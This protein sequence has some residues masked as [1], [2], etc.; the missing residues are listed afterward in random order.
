MGQ[1]GTIL[2]D[3]Y[4][5]VRMV[6]EG[7]MGV[8]YEG[9]HLALGRK[10]AIKMLHPEFASVDQATQ[11]FMQEAQIAGSLGHPNLCE[12]TDIGTTSEGVP[13]MVMPFL[14]GETLADAVSDAQE[15]GEGFEAAR[16]VGIVGQILSALRPAHEA[17]IVH[18]DLK[19]ENVFLMKA[20]DRDDFVKILDFGISKIVGGAK[21]S[22]RR[23]TS[24]GVVVGTPYYMAPEQASGSR[25]LDHRVD[26]YAVG[27]LLYELLTGQP[28]YE[29][30]TYNE[31]IIKIVK[32]D[33]VSPDVLNPRIPEP[34]VAVIMRALAKDREDRFQDVQTFQKALLVAGQ[35]V[36][37]AVGRVGPPTEGEPSAKAQEVGTLA[38]AAAEI[39]GTVATVS[40]H[41]KIADRRS[42][43][44]AWAVGGGLA[45]LVAL[46]IFFSGVLR[47]GEEGGAPKPVG[48]DGIQDPPMRRAVPDGAPAAGPSR[49]PLVTIEF[50]G[51]GARGRVTLGGKVL[52]GGKVTV[53]RS[54][55]KLGYRAEAPGH[56]PVEGSVTPDRDQVVEIRLTAEPGLGDPSRPG[57]PRPPEVSG[58]AMGPWTAMPPGGP[59]MDIS[60]VMQPPTGTGAIMGR[61]GTSLK[62]DYDAED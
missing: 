37:E 6:G 57:A 5:V 19:P 51:L 28:P 20:G 1:E 39:R 24:T 42:H 14:E 3:R 25:D 49:S 27:A 12:V 40:V 53:P 16:S 35:G 59:G 33:V 13:Y 45:L 23:L 31:I 50:T 61:H 11:R 15:R 60:G 22:L 7:G 54:D 46:V 48:S 38:S 34:L 8:V 17:G 9:R 4:E 36:G 55:W 26:I 18:R 30:E 43:G 32:G 56:L 44:W 29:G 21:P 47:P 62:T 2:N 52:T 10:V 58:S 41:G